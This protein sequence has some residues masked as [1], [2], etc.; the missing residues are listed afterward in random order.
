[1]SDDLLARIARGEY[2][3]GDRM[4][5]EKLLM[6]EYRVG[7]NTVREAMN[8]LRTLGMVEIR[9][10]LGA[11][12]LHTPEENA[13]ANSARSALLHEQAMNEL[14]E[15]RLIVEPA[16]AE[17]AAINRTDEDLFALRRAL[18]HY[19]VAYEMS[20]PVWEADI[21]FHEAIMTA[22][23][24][25]VLARVLAPVSDLIIHARK[26][27]AE[28]LGV[29]ELGLREHDEI[30]AAIEARASKRARRAMTAHIE[31]ATRAISQLDELTNPASPQTPA[32]AP[33]SR[34][35]KP[36]T[37]PGRRPQKRQPPAKP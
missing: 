33:T 30:A 12:V 31:S 23:G 6:A 34:R 2:K 26:A 10:R 18:T 17:M 1:V 32:R 29:V 4:P 36:S 24:N 9:P 22:S 16:A 8:S 11:T 37:R 14:Y 35:R 21:E 25:A 28:I 3:A 15:V 7:R 20:T 13:L 19:R 5:S 27:T